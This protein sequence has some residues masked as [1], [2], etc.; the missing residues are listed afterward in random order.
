MCDV[1]LEN[2]VGDDVPKPG[3]VHETLLKGPHEVLITDSVLRCIN[4][5]GTW[6][7]EGWVALDHFASWWGETT[8]V[9]ENT[10][11]TGWYTGVEFYNTDPEDGTTTVTAD[12]DGFHDN[13]NGNV[14]EITEDVRWP[15]IEHCP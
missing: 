6:F 8:T 13:R 7:E 1:V 15:G 4:C 3:I 12:C 2:R 14:R 10:E 9:I 5:Q 11:V